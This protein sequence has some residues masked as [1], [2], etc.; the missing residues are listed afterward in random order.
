[1]AGHPCGAAL[2]V[3][4]RRERFDR[5]WYAGPVG[6]TDGSGE[7]EFVVAL[8]SA[9]VRGADALLYAGAGIVA[10][11]DP[12]AEIA[13]TRLKLQPMLSALLEL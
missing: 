12:D 5:G 4:N 3:L 6:W 7:G 1:V 9:L 11:S 10:G 8:R 13:E 2:E